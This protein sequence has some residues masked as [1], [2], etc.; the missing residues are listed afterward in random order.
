MNAPVTPIPER[1]AAD[2]FGKPPEGWRRRFYNVIFEADTKAGRTFDI[3]LVFVILMSILVVVLDSVPALH[4]ANQ[5]S[6]NGLEWF[7]TVLFT[8]EYLARL[9]SVRR[10]WRYA[11]SFFGIIDLLSVLP[12]Y[13]SLFVPEAAALLDIRILRLLRV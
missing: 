5:S 7:F 4:T 13:F 3:I 9:A 6:M 1:A 10:P 2:A 11:T 8:L 12:T